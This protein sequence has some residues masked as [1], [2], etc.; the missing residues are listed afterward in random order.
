MG[1]CALDKNWFEITRSKIKE[2]RI[3]PDDQSLLGLA[4]INFRGTI[5]KL[6]NYTKLRHVTKVVFNCLLANWSKNK[7]GLAYS[8]LPEACSEVQNAGN[9]ML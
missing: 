9:L 7:G 1:S 6:V 2:S 3:T 8:I 5:Q 4:R